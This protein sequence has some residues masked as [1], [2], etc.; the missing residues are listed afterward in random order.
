MSCLPMRALG[1]SPAHR[2][3]SWLGPGLGPRARSPGS[4]P[5]DERGLCPGAARP[6][7]NAARWRR[8]LEG[9]IRCTRPQIPCERALIPGMPACGRGPHRRWP[10]TGRPCTGVT[11]SAS[12]ASRWG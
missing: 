6:G 5:L 4:V 7:R 10:R 1:T 2:L 9:A 3:E 8:P 12:C 11:S